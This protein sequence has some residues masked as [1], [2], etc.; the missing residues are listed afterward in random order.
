M[1]I[2]IYAIWIFAIGLGFVPYAIFMG[3]V[4]ID[5]TVDAPNR[6]WPGCAML[7]SW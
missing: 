4:E 5:R 3:V 7:L 1:Q 6:T 2:S